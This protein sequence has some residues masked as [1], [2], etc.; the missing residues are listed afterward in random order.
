MKN[1]IRFLVLTAAAVG[2]VVF[3]PETTFAD[4]VIGSFDSTR[5]VRPFMGSDYSNLRSNLSNAANFGPGGIVNEAVSFA[6][7]V[8]SVTAGALSGLDVFVI[9][10]V[11]S[12]S[13]S[14]VTD[15]TNFVLGVSAR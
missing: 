9:T 7:E 3:S 14:E 13:G 11:E 4:I 10:E 8:S 15:L 12:L 2:L 6:P 5:S 1:V